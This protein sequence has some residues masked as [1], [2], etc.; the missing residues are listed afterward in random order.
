MDIDILFNYV[1]QGFFTVEKHKTVDLFIF[2]YASGPVAQGKKKEWDDINKKMRGLIVDSK[3]TIHARSFEKFFTF[4]EYL[5]DDV[6][7]T[8][9]DQEINIKDKSYKIFDKVDGSL[10][11]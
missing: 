4:K 2:G 1:K 11:I 7:L 8:L 3:G 6:I 9:E 10:S 5:S